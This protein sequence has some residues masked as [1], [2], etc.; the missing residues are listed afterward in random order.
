MPE[1]LLTKLKKVAQINGTSL[2]K[3]QNDPIFVAVK[4]SFEKETKSK[5][6]SIGSSKGSGS[7]KPKKDFTSPGLTREEH[8]AMFNE[9]NS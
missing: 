1:E 5:K 6:A 9:R 4:E 2:I 8:E 7:V 3:A